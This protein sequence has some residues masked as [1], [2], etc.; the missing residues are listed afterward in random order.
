MQHSAELRKCAADKVQPNAG[1]GTQWLAEQHMPMGKL[2]MSCA[3]TCTFA[4]HVTKKHGHT[5]G[6]TDF[7][8]NPFVMLVNIKS[9]PHISATIGFFA[10]LSL[11][12]MD[13]HCSAQIEHKEC[14]RRLLLFKYLLSQLCSYK[15]FTLLLDGQQPICTTS[16]LLTSSWVAKV[17][18]TCNADD[19]TLTAQTS[20]SSQHQHNKAGVQAQQTHQAGPD[21][22]SV[23]LHRQAW[24]ESILPKPLSWR[25]GDE[26]HPE[27]A[28]NQA[29]QDFAQWLSGAHAHPD[30]VEHMQQL[31]AA[32]QAAA[33]P[34]TGYQSGAGM[35]PQDEVLQQQAAADP[36]AAHPNAG[37]QDMSD[38]RHVAEPEHRASK[39]STAVSTDRH[40]GYQDSNGVNTRSL[41]NPVQQQA[42]LNAGTAAGVYK[43]YIG[44]NGKGDE[45]DQLQQQVVAN[46]GMPAKTYVGYKDGNGFAYVDQMPVRQGSLQYT[47]LGS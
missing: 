38:T 16:K 24:D 41:G 1:G 10:D 27:V 21:Q 33:W 3:H 40:Q 5:A 20:T 9:R 30:Y 15:Y 45:I 42:G 32:S 6:C 7:C 14:F 39:S 46:S 29:K 47:S 44:S 11:S 2:G 37:N 31:A 36:E 23:L 28:L 18:V 35:H 25:K 4:P 17:G 34:N 43:G 12:S 26:K 22:S 8:H 19:D 13:V